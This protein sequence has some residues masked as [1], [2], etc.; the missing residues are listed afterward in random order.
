MSQT[1][2]HRSGGGS[3]EGKGGEGNN[4][5]LTLNDLQAQ[6]EKLNRRLKSTQ[7]EAAKYR[8]ERNELRTQIEAAQAEHAAQMEEMARRESELRLSTMIERV[9][10]LHDLDEELLHA[11]LTQ[12]YGANEIDPR[13]VDAQS[14]IMEL[15]KQAV[16][17]FPGIRIKIPSR[18]IGL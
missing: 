2:P 3:S 1:D 17:R 16:Q 4:P 8:V 13:D 18:R 10:R 12:K 7:D 9:A 5:A 11:A 14:R 15:T 6:V